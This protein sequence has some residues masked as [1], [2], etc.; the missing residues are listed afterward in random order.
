MRESKYPLLEH[1]VIVRRARIYIHEPILTLEVLLHCQV[2]KRLPYT[3]VELKYRY[4][5]RNVACP[6]LDSGLAGSDITSRTN[7]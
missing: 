3:L 1:S 4:G 2:E 6:G 5:C 7:W